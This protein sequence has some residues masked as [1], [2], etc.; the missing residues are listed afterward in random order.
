MIFPLSQAAISSVLSNK[1]KKHKT[2]RMTLTPS[3][4]ITG[5]R[6]SPQ[7]H[8]LWSLQQGARQL[9]FAAQSAVCIA[10]P[11]QPS[12]LRDALLQVVQ[13]HEILRTRFPCLPGMQV[14]L[15]VIDEAQVDW[16]PD[17][18]LQTLEAA[19]QTIRLEAAWRSLGS[20]LNPA[21]G[22]VVR[23]Q[24]LRLAE[25]QWVLHLALP[26]LSADGYTLQQLVQA[27]RDAYAAI[28]NSQLDLLEQPE[29]PQYADLAEWQHELLIADKTAEGRTYW[30]QQS[31]CD[32]VS[33]RLPG[34]AVAPALTGFHPQRI[35]VTLGADA[36]AQL[37]ALTDQQ[38][39]SLAAGFLTLWALL[40]WRQL[41]HSPLVGV[42]AHGRKYDELAAALGP[43]TRYLP[44][45]IAFMPEQSFIAALQAVEQDIQVLHQWQEYFDPALL[46]QA[47][48]VQTDSQTGQ[49][50]AF[51]FAFKPLSQ[52]HQAGDVEFYLEQGQ[53]DLE[54]LKLQLTIRPQGSTCL[55]E[56]HYDANLFS[57]TAV[58][59]LAE[60]L[61]TLLHSIVQTPTAAMGTLNL[62]S[63]RLRQ[64]LLSEWNQTADPFPAASTIHQ[65]FEQQAT[66]IPDQ[67]AVVFETRSLTYAELNA[68][69]NQ[70]AHYLRAQGVQPDQ[71]VGLAVERS[72][73]FVI[74]LLAILKAG[75]AYLPLDPTLPSERLAGMVQEA[76]AQIVLTQVSEQTKWKAHP[77][78]VIALGQ[79]Q[80]DWS[81]ACCDNPSTTATAENLIYVIYTSGS[82][83]RPKG[84][85]VEHRHLV[86]YIYGVRPQLQLPTPVNF[87]LVSTIAADLGHTM[88]FSSLCFGGC[89]HLIAAERATHP[90]AIAD[91][92]TQHPIDCLKIVPSHLGALL[93]VSNPER[94]LPRHQLILGGET[95]SPSLIEQVGA[96][97][98]TCHVLN[99]YGP[100]ET[101]VGVLTYGVLAGAAE[102]PFTQPLPLGRPL[103][104]T[105]IYLLDAQQQLVP[106]GC[107]GELY[108]GGVGVARGYLYQPELTAERF[109]P[110]PPHLA[111]STATH[112]RLYRTGDLA[113]YRPDGNLEFLGRAD[114][115]VK[116]RGYRIELGEIAALLQ[117]HPAVREQA[118]IVRQDERGAKQLM[119]YVV[120]QPPQTLNTEQLRQFLSD[121]LPGYMIPAA[122]VGLKALPL[123][124]NGKID[125]QALP[126]PSRQP[127]GELPSDHQPQ[128]PVERRL[129][130]I[131]SELFGLEAIGRH[132]NFFELGGDS[133]LSMQIIARASRGGIHI[134]PKQVFECPTI[135]QLATVTR[136]T[137]TLQAEQ[138]L[139]TG[140]APLT[141]IQQWFFAPAL[142][143]PHHWNQSLLLELRQPLAATLIQQTL[144]HLLHH[145][146]ALR[147]QFTQTA[148][149]W[150]ASHNSEAL[151]APFCEFDWSE[152]STAEQ[153]IRLEVIASEQQASLSLD[154]APLMRVALLHL[155]AGGQRL[156]WVGHHLIVDGV[157]WRILLEDFQTVYRQLSQ[158]QAVQ[159]P[160]KTTSWQQW[161]NRL[162]AFAQSEALPPELP[163][164]LS[165]TSTVPTVLQRA[166][167]RRHNTGAT[168]QTITVGLSPSETQT[169]LQDLPARHRTQIQD[170][171]LTALLQ[172]F[173]QCSGESSLCLDLEGHGREDLFSELDVSRTVGWFTTLFPVQLIAPEQAPLIEVL[174]SVKAQLQQIPH[175]GIGYGL[176]R[177]LNG[178]EATAD[179]GDRNPA[180]LRFNYLGQLERGLQSTT[181]ALFNL[182]SESPGVERSLRNPRPYLLDINSFVAAGQLQMQWSYSSAIHEAATIQA[183]ADTFLAA[184]RSLLASTSE[185]PTPLLK[186]TALLE[187]VQI[188][189]IEDLAAEAVLDP[190]IQPMGARPITTAEPQAILVTGATGF[191]GAALVAELL[192]QTSAQIYCLI[193]AQDAATAQ[194][195][196][197]QN[198]EVYQLWNSDQGD[199]LIPVV[200]DLVQPYLGL[201][202]TAFQ[203]LAQTVDVIYHNGAWTHLVYPYAALKASN[204]LGTQE[205]I[206]LA[207]QVKV[208]PVHLVS[209]LSVIGTAGRTEECWI[210]EQDSLD[211]G[212]LPATGYAQTKWVAEQLTHIAQSRGLPVSI[213]RAGRISGHCQTG[214]CNTSDR[215]YRMI[216]GCIQLGAIP[217]VDLTLDMTPVD[218]M[219]QVIV[220]LSQRPSSTGQVFHISN[221]K[222]IQLRDLATWICSFG[223][224]L[225]TLSYD[226]WQA[227]LTQG[228][229]DPQNALYPLIPF[230][231]KQAAQAA[232][233]ALKFDDRNTR[234]GLA[235]AEI[236]C[237]PIDDQLLETYFS[238]LIRSQFLPAPTPP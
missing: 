117:Q 125:R 192:Q 171:L 108:I 88:I 105:Q 184:L 24:L 198:L 111:T 176:L 51:G 236:T 89:L 151:A 45:A 26:A 62:V 163:H 55:A 94:V 104:N 167:D 224:P 85:A 205:I 38:Q 213:Y 196:L 120:P 112:Q 178:G 234:T 132:D 217:D 60:Q 57:P 169:L 172:A 165:T 182:A 142:P 3:P 1:N 212:G 211:H 30:Q 124:A 36:V 193:R 137:T 209:T 221:P 48:K 183:L 64:R 126:A 34:E 6:L 92:F 197:Q 203:R 67:T 226:A 161:A 81:H 83:G 80:P 164:W 5:F 134:T 47:G 2:A 159:L 74:G 91:Y 191:L 154:Q 153:A 15:Q 13:C 229:I 76:Q 200:G 39:T 175:H 121:R 7:Q 216:K 118:V 107:V 33:Q 174:Q 218:Y 28:T 168:T 14:P 127:I 116:I 122:I 128:T 106:L 103:A 115:Q 37:Q 78:Q 99:H 162:Q 22:P 43:L 206:R 97:A 148:T 136:T 157:S 95:A 65:L 160:A 49:Y 123:T 102:P 228:D 54:P 68:Q 195:R 143:E 139:V 66:Q 10:G 41:N 135:A 61:S 145:H 170:V 194:Q 238:Y 29:V 93:T 204:V 46:L 84:V 219:A 79:S 210:Q 19:T 21:E 50:C 58:S 187:P 119:A 82:T 69:A 77:A 233:A 70:L 146:D 227:Q 4:A 86:N 152:L 101:T 225:K 131:W 199:R 222:P 188:N 156:L 166:G 215:L 110:L 100:T 52:R 144:H 98:P 75:G 96:I 141:P 11:L 232:Q 223:Y 18:N 207:S 186:P 185:S 17:Q 149:G 202:E 150:Q 42:M 179:L 180:A 12:Q 16:L 158:E 40:L 220:H 140:T 109:I 173:Q 181:T 20:G 231:A 177:Y 133:I 32:L 23:S 147:L 87:A 35:A 72:L 90:E 235:N 130:A 237:P 113:R 155:G 71:V 31:F 8:R 56:L 138:G 189:T 114:D 190:S 44:V 129:A 208:K 201:S 63:D 27:L 214:I 53:V 59:L 230:F 73:E 9:P 25:Q